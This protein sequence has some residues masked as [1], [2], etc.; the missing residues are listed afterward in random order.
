MNEDEN[1]SKQETQIKVTDTMTKDIRHQW[2]TQRK[3]EKNDYKEMG[4]C[5]VVDKQAKLKGPLPTKPRKWHFQTRISLRSI[6]K[7]IKRLSL[8]QH[9]AISNSGLG[10][11]LNLRCTKLDH[12]LY[13]LLIQKFDP[14]TCSLNVHGRQLLITEQDVHKLLGIPAKGKTIELNE[15]SKEFPKLF[16]ELGVVQ[17]AIKLNAL[18]DYLTKTDGAGEKFKRIFALY[19]LGAF[20]CPTTKDVVK[21]SFIHLVQNVDGMKD[22]NWSKFTLQFLVRGLRK[23]SSKSQSQPNGCLFLIML[24][25]FDRLAP[26]GCHVARACSVPCLADWGDAEIKETLK[27]FKN[28]GGC[29]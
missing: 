9:D 11:L 16:E 20:L 1:K 4:R 6:V 29:C 15:S 2:R 19:I 3:E 18:R 7:I 17:G 12:D 26:S 28:S 5:S 22:Y 24:F 25:Y 8:E 23:H 21:Q 13:E 27:L 10:G 14:K